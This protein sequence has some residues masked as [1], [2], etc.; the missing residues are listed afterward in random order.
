MLS[1]SLK[2]ILYLNRRNGINNFALYNCAVGFASL[3]WDHPTIATMPWDQVATVLPGR[4][5]PCEAFRFWTMPKR[6]TRRQSTI[7]HHSWEKK[8]HDFGCDGGRLQF[9][10]LSRRIA[11]G[12]SASL[13]PGAGPNEV[14]EATWYTTPGLIRSPLLLPAMAW[15]HRWIIVGRKNWAPACKWGLYYAMRSTNRH[16]D[17][18]R[19]SNN[20]GASE[21]QR[22]HKGGS[23]QPQAQSDMTSS[24]GITSFRLGKPCLFRTSQP[25]NKLIFIGVTHDRK[26]PGGF[27][28]E[29]N[30]T[31]NV[32]LPFFRVNDCSS[33]YVARSV[34]VDTDQPMTTGVSL[35]TPRV[36]CDSCTRQNYFVVFPK[37]WVYCLEFWTLVLHLRPVRPGSMRLF[38]KSENQ[39]DARRREYRRCAYKR[40]KKMRVEQN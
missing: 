25:D 2:R 24:F 29:P 9:R 12:G 36:Q 22:D 33:S 17:V 31:T 8:F 35:W 18:T 39:E 30:R 27:L 14:Q 34:Y 4:L 16:S 1:L 19:D 6:R 20:E 10:D 38:A 7:V 11:P 32:R 3:S 13:L 23:P 15:C 21:S 26:H 28:L 37:D 5:Q 40:I